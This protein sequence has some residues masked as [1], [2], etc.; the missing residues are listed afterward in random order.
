MP[1]DSAIIPGQPNTQP[2]GINKNHSTLM[3]YTG[4]NDLDFV[5]MSNA[6]VLEMRGSF[7]RI[8]D[9]WANWKRELS[10]F[11]N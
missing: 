8:N 1:K 6:L 11:I 3:K 7:K 5:T 10:M 2:T 4:E 9:N